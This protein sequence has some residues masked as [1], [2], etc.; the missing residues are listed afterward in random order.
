MKLESLRSEID[1]IDS[2]M[3]ELFKKRMSVSQKIGQYKKMNKL[4]IL[5]ENREKELLEKRKN[6]FNDDKQWPLYE[7]FIKEMMRLSKANQK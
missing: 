3:M 6:E 7:S 2:E 1:K 4:P 5:D